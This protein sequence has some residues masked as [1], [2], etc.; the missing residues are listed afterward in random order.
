MS[1]DITYMRGW[2]WR[3]RYSHTGIGIGEGEQGVP[4]GRAGLCLN[5]REVEVE[6]DAEQFES[7]EDHS[8]SRDWSNTGYF[9]QEIEGIGGV[10]KKKV[11]K[12]VSIGHVV[13]EYE[14]ERLHGDYLVKERTGKVRSWCAHCNRVVLGDKDKQ[15]AIGE[16]LER[17]SSSGSSTGSM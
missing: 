14:E 15:T 8:S 17:V 4:C 16:L 1:E 10:V 7:T 9:T 11:K 13:K 6:I 3:H 2:S 5:V 12:R